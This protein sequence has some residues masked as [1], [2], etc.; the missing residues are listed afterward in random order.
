M[1]MVTQAKHNLRAMSEEK[2]KDLDLRTPGWSETWRQAR[3][4]ATQRNRGKKRSL[5]VSALQNRS[6]NL[7]SQTM[8]KKSTH[9]LCLDPCVCDCVPQLEIPPGHNG[10]CA[11][12]QE[13][14]QSKR[15]HEVESI[16][17]EDV[18]VST[19]ALVEVNPG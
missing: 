2:E 18:E 14:A 3:F 4:L 15:R 6:Y 12:V 17:E 10:E 8:E 9:D 13:S 16:V 1:A 19:R 11:A 7:R 5:E